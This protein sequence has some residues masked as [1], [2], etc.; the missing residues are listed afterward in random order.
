[1]AGCD[2]SFR[3]LLYNH[4]IDLVRI[5][6][7]NNFKKCFKYGGFIKSTLAQDLNFSGV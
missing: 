7:N 4:I 2:V 1:M 3:F 6:L 5:V